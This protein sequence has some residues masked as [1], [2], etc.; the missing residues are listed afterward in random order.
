[1]FK[2]HKPNF[3][4]V[5]LIVFELSCSQTDRLILKLCFSDSGRSKTWRFVKISSSNFLTITILSLC[6]LHIRERS[7]NADSIRVSLQ[8]IRS[9]QSTPPPPPPPHSPNQDG[10]SETRNLMRAAFIYTY[11]NRLR[12]EQVFAGY[13]PTGCF[14]LSYDL[15]GWRNRDSRKASSSDI[16]QR[17][18]VHRRTKPRRGT[19]EVTQTPSSQP[20]TVWGQLSIRNLPESFIAPPPLLRPITRLG[21]IL[22]RVTSNRCAR[23][24][25]R[26][27]RPT[28]TAEQTEKKNIL[29][30]KN[31]TPLRD[32][33][34]LN[35]RTVSFY[36]ANPDDSHTPP[37]TPKRGSEITP[38]FNSRIN[39]VTRF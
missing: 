1:M 28:S 24:W 31:V 35:P 34:P 39:R 32:S 7:E 37:S 25:Y 27:H 14:L 23:R 11:R 16:E 8:P 20:L 15:I 36:L 30:S 22:N 13:V 38:T 3:I 18:H 9:G 29:G 5:A 21:V 19:Q 2:D 12:V 10:S 26:T 4:P 17:P 33:S 6:I